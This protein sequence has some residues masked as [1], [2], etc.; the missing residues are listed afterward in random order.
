MVYLAP[1][2]TPEF[3]IEIL[4]LVFANLIA[5]KQKSSGVISAQPFSAVCATDPRHAKDKVYD[6][7]KRPAD[8]QWGD[9]SSVVGCPPAP[10]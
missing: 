10:N 1:T 6:S 5:T 9:F 7:K 2:L 8:Q 3:S 4:P